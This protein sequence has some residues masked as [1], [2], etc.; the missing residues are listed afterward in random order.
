[1]ADGWVQVPL[2]GA[3]ELG[4]I[5]RAVGFAGNLY[6]LDPAASQIWRYVATDAGFDSERQGVLV[7]GTDIR[8]AVDFSLDGDVYV[9]TRGGKVL[10]FSGGRP[11]PFSMDGLDKPLAAPTAIM[12][13]AE[14]QGVYVADAGNKRIV[15][16]DKSGRMLRQIILSER[17]PT[18]AGVIAD[19]ARKTLYL[20]TDRQIVA[21]ALPE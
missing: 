6:L 5:E 8:D 21:A 1:V 10:K 13:G 11:Q 18:V 19:E 2:R 12:T 14:Q 7:A 20:M 9:V 15:V 4:P 16:F 3:A 17:L